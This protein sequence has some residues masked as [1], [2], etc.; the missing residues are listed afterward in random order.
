M[1]SV[2]ETQFG[3]AEVAETDLGWFWVGLGRGSVAGAYIAEK[4]FGGSGRWTGTL[5]CVGLS[6]RNE[7]MGQGEQADRA[8]H[9]LVI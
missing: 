9:I 6:Q 7:V 8:S 2:A 1:A 3:A 5:R 4:H